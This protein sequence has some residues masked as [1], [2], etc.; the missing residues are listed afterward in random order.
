MF[1]G[2]ID[3]GFNAIIAIGFKYMRDWKRWYLFN[4]IEVGIVFICALVF[5]PESPRYLITN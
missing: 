2:I 4:D 3:G 5:L 1:N